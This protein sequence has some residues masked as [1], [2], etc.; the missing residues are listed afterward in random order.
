MEKRIVEYTKSYK[1]DVYLVYRTVREES[2][3]NARK[4]IV[5]YSSFDLKFD[6]NNS[7]K[8]LCLSIKLFA[9]VSD[10]LKE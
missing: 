7:F 10:L 3:R 8:A 1:L 4:R 9:L 5:I 2:R 6:S